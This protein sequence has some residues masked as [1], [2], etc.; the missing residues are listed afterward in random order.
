MGFMVS[1]NRG[2]TMQTPWIVQQVMPT[3][4][5]DYTPFRK[6]LRASTGSWWRYQVIMDSKLAAISYVL[7]D[8]PSDKVRQGQ[9]ES[10]HRIKL[11][12]LGLNTSGTRGHTHMQAT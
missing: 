7:L 5:K 6:Q 12:H 11:V 3:A 2:I 1:P 8:K 4:V 10:H 9:Y